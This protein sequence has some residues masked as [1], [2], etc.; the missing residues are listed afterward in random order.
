M[1]VARADPTTGEVAGVFESIQPTDDDMGAKTPKEVKVTA[2]WYGR[3][4]A[5]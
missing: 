5:A 4:S 3:L 2:L 1:S